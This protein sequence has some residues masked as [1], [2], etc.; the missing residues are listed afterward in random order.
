M[1]QTIYVYNYAEMEKKLVSL[2]PDARI[3]GCID[4]EFVTTPLFQTDDYKLLLKF[5]DCTPTSKFG[6]APQ[7][8]SKEQANQVIQFI[9]NL[10]NGRIRYDLHIHCIGGQARSTAIAQFAAWLAGLDHK[11]IRT[12]NPFHPNEYVLK[13]L[14]DTYRSMIMRGSKQ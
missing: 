5:D 8:F 4:T 7:L 10:I 11:Y 13:L 12:N 3:I 14:E 9:L 1:I 6:L 2:P